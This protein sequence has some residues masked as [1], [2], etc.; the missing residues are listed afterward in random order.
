MS[1]NP[2]T[3]SN[4]N[5]TGFA[6]SIS[7]ELASRKE[8]SSRATFVAM[9]VSREWRSELEYRRRYNRNIMR[10]AWHEG[11]TSSSRM[12]QWRSPAA[13]PIFPREWSKDPHSGSAANSISTVL[14]ALLYLAQSPTAVQ[15]RTYVSLCARYVRA[16]E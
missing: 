5:S 2:I 12:A 8:T 4:R 13:N 3:Y 11:D 9:C 1:N 6:F 7:A 15:T 10:F 16:T 14:F